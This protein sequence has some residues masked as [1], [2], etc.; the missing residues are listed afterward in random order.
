MTPTELKVLAG[1]ERMADEMVHFTQELVR[2]PTVNPPGDCY[3]QCADLVARN[4]RD[5]GYTVQVLPAEGLPEHTA[6]YPRIN[7]VGTLSEGA[8]PKTLHFNGH[9]D[10]VPP[11]SGWT[12]DPFAAELRDGHI[13]GRGT[14]DQKAG[15]AAS[16]YAIEAIRRAGIRLAGRIEQSAT[17]DEESGGFGGVA[18]LCDAGYLAEGRQDYVVITEPLDP[19]RVCVGHRGVYWFELTTIGRIGHGSMPGLAINA[20]E[21]MTRLVQT[22]EDQLK[23]VLRQRQTKLPVAPLT[24]RR[25]SIN[26]NAIHAGQELGGWQTPAVP[27]RC[28]AIF[29]RRYLHE[30]SFEDVRAE[31]VRVLDTQGVA[32]ELRDLMRV[33]PLMGSPEDVLPVT[34]GRAIRD[35]LGLEPSFIASPGTY[36]Q[37]HVV[38]R[39]GIRECIAYGPGRLVLAHQPDEHVAVAD[40]VASAKVMALLALRL[41]N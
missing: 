30:E 14:C 28:T 25:P 24:A 36:D 32:Y 19:E 10:V 39:A 38:R 40:L 6:E 16:V 37:K 26:L 1:V 5:F 15:I 33:D 29:D 12:V 3:A 2:I 31:I 8:C 20:A 41:L 13:Y 7:V 11:G 34:A 27:D 21:Q 4:L 9:Y 18:W 23:P 17:A 35:A 22:F